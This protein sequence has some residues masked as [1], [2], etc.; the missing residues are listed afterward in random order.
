MTAHVVIHYEI[1]DPDGFD[2]YRRLA[3]PTHE[4]FG[5]E[6]DFKGEIT[7]QLEGADRLGAG[8]VTLSFPDAAAAKAWYTSDAYEAAK[9]ARADAATMTISIV[10]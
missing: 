1:T 7:E 2:R 8:V 3:G 10:Q 4:P 9:A 6:L 5:G